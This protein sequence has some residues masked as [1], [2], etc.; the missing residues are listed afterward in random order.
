[1]HAEVP[2]KWP[3]SDGSGL[4]AMRVT[5]TSWSAQADATCCEAQSA[6]QCSARLSMY[7]IWS[8][9][10]AAHSRSSQRSRVGVRRRTGDDGHQLF[11]RMVDRRTDRPG[12]A[13]DVLERRREPLEEG[14]RAPPSTGSRR[15]TPLISVTACFTRWTAGCDL[16]PK[17]CRRSAP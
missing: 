8:A 4:R 1:M 5:P 14:D 11:D 17:A 6:P 9:S 7:G 13:V 16:Q 3:W 2:W 10:W 15:A 12:G